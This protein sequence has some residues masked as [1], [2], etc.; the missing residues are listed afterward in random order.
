MTRRDLHVH[1]LY[2]DGKSTPEEAVKAA[3]EKGF[4]QIGL[5]AHSYLPFDE[6][7]CIKPEKTLE[8]QGEVRRLKEKYR[9][10]IEV[11]CGIEEDIFSEQSRE[12]FDYV[13]G[14]VHYIKQGDKYFSVDETP[15]ILKNLID[16]FYGGDFYACAADYFALVKEL[17]KKRPTVIGHFDLIKKFR[18][19]IPFDEHEPRYVSAWKSAADE[20][21]K[22]GAPFEINTGGISRGYL[23][24]PY[25]SPEIAEYIKSQGGRLLLSSDAHRAQ[26]I[27]FGF[28]KWQELL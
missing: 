2:C 3:L 11:F 13:I 14:S 6:E 12:G 26:D 9:G 1:T 23:D 21:L 24:E 20:L 8:F 4:E 18:R 7:S 19:D 10:N 25:P 15:D 17:A 27:G 16:T 5:V 22:L 28:E